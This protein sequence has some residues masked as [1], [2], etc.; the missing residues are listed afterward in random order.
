MQ[1]RQVR[2]QSA[3]QEAVPAS[4]S[5]SPDKHRFIYLSSEDNRI[6]SSI[7]ISQL[8]A[9]SSQCQLHLSMEFLSVVADS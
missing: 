4:S 3:G 1:K 2:S 5:T 9:G 8:T 7:Y 6:S